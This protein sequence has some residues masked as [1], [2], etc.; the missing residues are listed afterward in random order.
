MSKSVSTL[1]K[2][3]STA[4]CA[5]LIASAVHA[6]TY[7]V[8]N[9][10]NDSN[11]GTSQGTAWKTAAKVN[12]TTFAAGDQILF[13]RG[14][15]WRESIVP[16]ASGAT[17][18]P[19]TYAD[20]G[21]G[22][23]PTFY[24][25]DVM[26]NANFTGGGGSYTYNVG[27]GFDANYA[28][29]LQNHV[30]LGAG[31]ASYN[32]P[33]VTV[34]IGTDPRTDGK[35]YTFCKRANVV[36]SNG[37]SH[38]VFRNLIADETVANDGASQGYGMRAEGS[39]DILFENCEALRCGRHNMACINS[40]Y[41][42]FKG[43]YVAYVAP[44]INAGNSLFV[45]YCDGNL[46]ASSSHSV[47]ENCRADN[48]S[49]YDFYDGHSQNG[50]PMFVTFINPTSAESK[51]YCAS[52]TGG[53]YAFTNGTLNAGRIEM[54]TAGCIIDGVTFKGNAFID[55]WATNATIQNCVWDNVNAGE[56]AGVL[57]RSG[58]VGDT[59]RFNTFKLSG[60][61]CLGFYGSATGLKFYGNIMIGTP[62]SAGNA[63]DVSYAD[64]NFYGSTP[65]T[66]MGQSWASWTGGGKDTHAKTGDPL[67]VGGGDYSLQ[68][69]STAI[70]AAS[71][72]QAIP[73]TDKTGASRP[74]GAAADMGAYEYGAAPVAPVITS[75]TTANGT[76]GQAFSYQ[77]TA[78]GSPTNFN[79]TGLPAGLS[80]N[81]NTGVISGTPSSSGSSSVTLSAIGAGGTGTAT[82]TITITAPGVPVITS[83]TTASA[84]KSQP[85]SYQI[86]ATQSPTNY[87]ATGLPAG[88]TV[89]RSTGLISGT[90]TAVGTNSASLSAI[91]AGGTG[92]ATLTITVT[93][94]P[95]GPT[96][97]MAWWKLDESSGTT[98]ADASGNNNTGTLTGGTW[99]P[100]G[101]QL[102]GALQLNA[103]S[104][105]NCGSGAS[106][107][108]PSM[109]V[110]F[111]M[112]A[113]SLQNANPIDK[114]PS[115]TTVGYAVKLR[116]TG[117]IW[118][119][120]G[121]E[122]GTCLDVYGGASMYSAGTWVH[123]ACSFDSATGTMKMYKNGVVESH[124]PTFAVTLNAAATALTLSSTREQYN[125][126]FDDVRVYDHALT[127]SDIAAVMA[128]GGSGG[129]TIEPPTINLIQPSGN[130]P[131]LSWTSAANTTYAVYKS[132]NLQAGW[133]ITALTNITGDGTAKT[134]TDPA[135]FEPAAFYRMTAR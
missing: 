64:Y 67:F 5:M 122:P 72:A 85:F 23:K 32:S 38:I 15:V 30:F 103:G 29:V 132:T 62:T 71:T 78:S 80:I 19:I 111:W 127:A 74:Q 63:G 115:N 44:A 13:E 56:V 12:G 53:Q 84:T 1:S 2:S 102:Q 93:A 130:K 105:L 91:G 128:G 106:L 51:F 7:Y 55:M 92:T 22:N 116:D 112:K 41:V 68:A 131:Q 33:N 86:T 118:F 4:A 79:A 95:P 59:I 90:P 50:K 17:G 24:G 45:S 26:V 97:L 52:D 117:T 54:W 83:A 108:T 57:V 49:G 58:S 8:S 107:N 110:C 65:G 101:G 11:N 3:I 39:T 31:P 109:T 36:A 37:K 48:Q 77:I 121:A 87:N 135:P 70:N 75:S 73:A 81:R 69:G 99:Q 47:Y 76:T 134:F 120:V 94:T 123:L 119:R 98:A 14:G 88:L 125:G 133:I 35:L 82:L 129:T 43:C 34:S 42:T 9:N 61:N 46:A 21:S 114:L 40:D 66:I 60:N 113:D 20:Y 124:Q 104:R 25:S 28:Y 96:G 6:A 10:G 89:N 27:A 126:A 18:N 100:A 16:S